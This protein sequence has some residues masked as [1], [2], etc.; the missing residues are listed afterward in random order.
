MFSHN[1]I[2]SA[3]DKLAQANGYSTSGLAKKAGLDPTTFNKSKRVTADG[4]PRWPSTE[5]ISKSLAATQ[6]TLMD[7]VG[8]IED[9]PIQS[10]AQ[11]IEH[12]EVSQSGIKKLNQKPLASLVVTQDDSYAVTL[13]SAQWA[14]TYKKG[15]TLLVSP[16]TDLQTD[17]KL[18]VE[19]ANNDI[20]IMSYDS[21]DD[22]T[23][24]LNAIILNEPDRRIQKTDI[25]RCAKILWASQ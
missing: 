8:F 6:A 15:T 1:E 4:K 13:T 2:W 17:D 10:T 11:A 5:S 25:I 12:F 16:K 19:T 23:L 20:F 24:S 3:I 9:T 21:Q 18:F 7:L 14:P 22:D